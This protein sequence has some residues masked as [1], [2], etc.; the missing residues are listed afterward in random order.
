MAK[1]LQCNERAVF[2]TAQGPLC[3]T[4]FSAYYEDTVARVIEK[5]QMITSGERICVGFSGGK[6]STVL[7]SVLAKLDLGAE[8]IAVTVDEGIANY[9]DDTI[10][11]AQ[12]TIARLPVFVEH[13]IISFADVCG[14][15]LDELLAGSPVRACSVCGT[16]RRRALNM[17]A[18]DCAADKIATGHCLDDES[19]SIVMNY[20]RGDITK[21]CATQNTNSAELFI[22]RIKPLCRLTE[23]ETVA[24]G[25]VN[26][27][28]ETLPECPYTKYAFR[29]GVR[30][31]LGLIEHARPG[32]LLRIAQ[33]HERL[34]AAVPRTGEAVRKMGVCEKCGEP[35]SGRLCAACTLLEEYLK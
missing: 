27:L 22:P 33:G 29:A 26:N 12:K 25:M 10:R 2:Q 19:Q 1:C 32:T 8:L 11:A 35:A 18:R 4:H 24:Y 21:L 31:E 5:Y 28:L 20:L 15:T 34:L 30:R 14:R 7:L 13:K 17:A 6:D 16:L 9:R 3:K 23:R